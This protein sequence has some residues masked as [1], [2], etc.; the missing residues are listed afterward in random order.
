VDDT[1]ELRIDTRELEKALRDLSFGHRSQIMGEA[2]QA[3]GDVMLEALVDHTPERTDEE[4][5]DSDS[6][7]PGMLK[8]SMTTELQLPNEQGGYKGAKGG[9]IYGMN[10]NPRIKVGPERVGASNRFGRVAYWQNNGWNLTAHATRADAN[11]KRGKRG[12]KAGRVIKA[13]T[14]KHMHFIEAAFDESAEQA[15]AAFLEVIQGRIFEKTEAIDAPEWNS[16]DV[17]FG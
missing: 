3:G 6:L 15:V 2:L 13:V 5:P 4:T 16:H 14:P 7:P 10:L 12:W 17:D 8:A 1:I 9:V 11:A